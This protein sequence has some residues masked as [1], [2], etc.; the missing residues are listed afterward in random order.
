VSGRLTVVAAERQ[1]VYHDRLITGIAAALAGC[2]IVLAALAV[3]YNPVILVVALAFAAAA[4]FMY[5][6]A[7][8]RLG[9]R[10]YRAV[11]R[12]ARRHADDDRKRRAEGG[13]GGFGAG[14]REDWTPPGGRRRRA[15]GGGQQRRR[16]SGGTVTG[17]E[18]S[19]A[20]AYR[21]LGLEPGADDA[22]VKR[23]YREKVKEVHPDTDSGDEEAFKQLTRAYERLT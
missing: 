22:A 18:P 8:G 3:R 7:S 11:E 2:A 5:Y 9:D 15:G 12:E 10:I 1:P 19:E 4:A 17:Q 23:A 20:Q 16:R 6:Q 14:P 21:T 13:R